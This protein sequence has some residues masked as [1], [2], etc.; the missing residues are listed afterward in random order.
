MPTH[1]EEQIA[2]KIR[3]MI[4][5][6]SKA[7]LEVTS[8]LLR[9][10][11]E[12][13]I[14]GTAKDSEQALSLA[15]DLQPQVILLDLDVV[16][17]NC[18]T[19]ISD[20]KCLLPSVSIIALTLQVSNSYKKVTLESGADEFVFKHNLVP[21]LMPAILRSVTRNQSSADSSQLSENS[22]IKTDHRG[23]C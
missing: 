9:R 2:L 3:V 17:R 21:D 8:H 19:I 20:L 13:D 12:L 15:A 18:S 23:E 14:V 4:V 1:T 10:Y 5:V 7:F 6:A 22:S 16:E 11:D